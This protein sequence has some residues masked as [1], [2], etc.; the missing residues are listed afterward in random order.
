MHIHVYIRAPMKVVCSIYM[1]VI[2]LYR[3]FCI[4]PLKIFQTFGFNNT[5]PLCKLEQA[6]KKNN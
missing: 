3:L 4:F 2:I 5:N 6:K 1:F